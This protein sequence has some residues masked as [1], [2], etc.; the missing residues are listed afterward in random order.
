MNVHKL[1][2]LLISFV[3]GILLTTPASTSLS[4]PG[5]LG[6]GYLPFQVHLVDDD[7]K[8]GKS[9][10]VIDLDGDEDLDLV[11]SKTVGSDWDVAWWENDGSQSFTR[12]TIDEDF[13]S[14]YSIFAADID[15]DTKPDVLGASSFYDQVVWWQNDGSGGLTK[16]IIDDNYDNMVYSIIAI[17]LDQD[18]DMDILAGSSHWESYHPDISWWE[19]DGEENFTRHDVTTAFER[20]YSVFIVD[21][22]GDTDLDILAGAHKDDDVS[23]WENDGDEN[24][25]EH[26]IDS[27]FDGPHSIYTADLDGDHDLDVLA[28]GWG[29]ECAIAWW[30]NDGSENF[31][32]NVLYTHD[33]VNNCMPNSILASDL[34][35]DGDQDV[36]SLLYDNEDIAWWENDGL[37]NFTPRTLA[38]DVDSISEL[39][40]IDLDRD[41]D[42]DIISAGFSGINWLEQEAVSSTVAALP[43]FDG[44]ESGELG[45]DW[46]I[47]NTY[48]GK[49]AVSDVPEEIYTGDYG[50]TMYEVHYIHGDSY[51][52]AILNI[53]LSTE[54]QVELSFHWQSTGFER[55]GIGVYLSDDQ[56]ENWE[57]ILD[58]DD[59]SGAWHFA[60]IDL[61][62]AA[63]DH[64]L[65]L[66]DH[67]QIKFQYHADG[68]KAYTSDHL[69]LDD[70]LV[71]RPPYRLYL[72]LL[73]KDGLAPAG[74]P[75]L[76]A[77]DNTDGDGSY[78]VTWSVVDHATR[79]TLEEDDN[80]D[81]SSSI[82][83]YVGAMTSTRIT[84]Q[85]LGTYYYRVNASNGLGTSDWSE[86]QS[87][88]VTK[89]P[90]PP[91]CPNAGDWVGDTNQGLPIEFGV[92][93]SCRVAD[94]KIE[95]LATCPTG[96]M[97]KT[98]TFDY[99]TMISNFKFEFDNDGDP[100]VN[101]T[102]TSLTQASGTWSTEFYIFGIG[103]CAGSGTWDANAP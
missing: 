10:V 32:K 71:R 42:L 63:A 9:I 2:L 49:V 43:F 25:T 90:P 46:G 20:T 98:K 37:G 103:N 41:D 67:F 92:S 28:A 73:L 85:D 81:F 31:Y 14:V 100:T 61:D 78:D 23:W 89:E 99:S 95:Y 52:M 40:T 77:I 57:Q 62:Q 36:I 80:S 24:F 50:L 26:S 82:I 47:D 79:Y 66:N 16:R 35:D 86:T 53:D 18:T 74:A 4:A 91:E 21:L 48:S 12:H 59:R 44:F 76:A 5:T 70:V 39:R 84:G 7:F 101:G 29:G 88:A 55:D 33:D 51:A 93:S 68:S 45:S 13:S 58:L 11:G 60:L 94:L 22:D 15:G 34:D 1:H 30:Q 56:G 97:W 75:V 3:L 65:T 83:A 6:T 72:P 87:V 96:L 38:F 54:S 8:G 102:F 19:N 27:N 64:G 69:W 17:D